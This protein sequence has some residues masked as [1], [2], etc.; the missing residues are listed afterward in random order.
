MVGEH[1]LGNH[2][3]SLFD[4]LTF[5]IFCLIA[6]ILALRKTTNASVVLKLSE[7]TKNHL[8]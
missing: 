5:A 6:R 1:Q 7:V 2:T 8:L 4:W 3:Q